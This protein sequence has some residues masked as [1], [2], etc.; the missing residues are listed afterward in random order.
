MLL[1]FAECR[2]VRCGILRLSFA[3]LFWCLGLRPVGHRSDKSGRRFTRPDLARAGS[4]SAGG[5]DRGTRANG[6]PKVTTTA[7]LRPG[8]RPAPAGLGGVNWGKVNWG[9]VSGGKGQSGKG[10]LGRR[11]SLGGVSWG[12]GVKNEVTVK[13]IGPNAGPHQVTSKN[14]YGEMLGLTRKPATDRK[15]Y[16]Q[17]T[18]HQF[19]VSGIDTYNHNVNSNQ[20]KTKQT[21][22]VLQSSGTN[23]FLAKT[24][25][26][27]WTKPQQSPMS[28]N[29]EIAGLAKIRR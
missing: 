14:V 6:R 1:V 5:N 26:D 9:K 17:K 7:R 24:N 3:G 22:Q 15:A 16:V 25:Q 21:M 4:G 2:G 18:R 27:G 10:Q 20:P 19:R 13:P 28:R 8:R 12:G 11:V 29:R 23:N